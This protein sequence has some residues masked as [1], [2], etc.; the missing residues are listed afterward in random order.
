MYATRVEIDP[1]DDNRSPLRQF[2]LLGAV[3]PVHGQRAR[4]T[5]TRKR[6]CLSAWSVSVLLA[7]SRGADLREPGTIVR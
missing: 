6:R 5:Q 1:L 4:A 2:E 3:D 7:T